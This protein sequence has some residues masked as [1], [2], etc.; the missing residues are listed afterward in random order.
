MI[1]GGVIAAAATGIGGIIAAI[2][3][4]ARRFSKDR[5]EIA[6]DRAEIDLVSELIRQRDEARTE[7]QKLTDELNALAEEN[8]QAMNTIRG[9]TSQVELLNARTSMLE[10]LTK[11]LTAALD[12][13]TEQLTKAMNEET[14][15]D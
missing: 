12:A 5:L 6:K 13:A 3:L 7:K 2:G 15:G 10:H 14:P 1:D 8:E 9:L 4:Y 11:R